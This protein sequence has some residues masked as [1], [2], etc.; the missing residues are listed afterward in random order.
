M[1]RTFWYNSN[2]NA[3]EVWGHTSNI[4]KVFRVRGMSPILTMI[5][6][7]TGNN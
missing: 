1:K 3:K 7:V 5:Y 4:G 2:I 6:N